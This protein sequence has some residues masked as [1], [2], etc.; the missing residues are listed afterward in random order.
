[1]ANSL[2]GGGAGHL[3]E[4]QF[5]EPRAVGAAALL[6]RLDAQLLL[7][8]PQGLFSDTLLFCFREC[9]L[10][11]TCERRPPLLDRASYSPDHVSAV[12]V[13]QEINLRPPTIKAH[14]KVKLQV[15]D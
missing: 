8:A 5:P 15:D 11:S 12:N 9:L 10:F 3:P 14:A 4:W 13:A 2:L 7:C 6:A 1:M